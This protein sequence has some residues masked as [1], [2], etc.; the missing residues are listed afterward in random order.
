MTELQPLR[1]G[2]KMRAVSKHDPNLPIT[3]LNRDKLR[4]ISKG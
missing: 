3:S 4:L 2:A 1:L